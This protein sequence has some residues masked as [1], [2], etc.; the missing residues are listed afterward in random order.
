MITGDMA[1]WAAVGFIVLSQIGMWIRNSA[2]VKTEIKNIYKKLDDE[3]TGLG[4]I[5]Q[6]VDEQKIHCAEV[7]TPLVA[8]VKGLEIQINENSKRKIRK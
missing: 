2:S 3:Y 6:S 7:S 8:R 1:Q 5:K 4:A